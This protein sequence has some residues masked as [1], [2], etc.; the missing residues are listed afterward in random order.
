M[1]NKDSFLNFTRLLILFI[2]TR[3]YWKCS[4]VT[5][6][7]VESSIWDSEHSKKH[8]LRGCSLMMSAKM[9]DARPPSIPYQPKSEI[10]WPPVPRVRRNQKLANPPSHLVRKH[11]LPHSNWLNAIHLSGIN[12]EF[13]SN[14][15]CLN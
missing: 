8:K 11:I 3:K 15:T 2:I 1:F 13:W 7:W 5:S 9:R 14:Y 6:P 12:N 10:G 4:R